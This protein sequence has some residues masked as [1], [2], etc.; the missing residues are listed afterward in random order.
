MAL[1]VLLADESPTIKKVFQLALQDYAVE[2]RSVSTGSDVEPV[3]RQFFPDIIFADV[4]L[5]KKNGYNVSASL[6]ASK[7]LKSIPIVLLCSHFMDVDEDKF[8]VSAANARLE[9]PF[10][11]KTLRNVIKNL[12]PKTKTQTLSEYLDFPTLP[13]ITESGVPAK[14]SSS[15]Q[16][17]P[18]SSLD[19]TPSPQGAPGNMGGAP[20]GGFSST[21]MEPVEMA[22]PIEVVG[23]GGDASD[24]QEVALGGDPLKGPESV[25][26]R[27]AEPESIEPE[28]TP[29]EPALE[30]PALELEPLGASPLSTVEEPS[31]D[32]SILQEQGL[33]SE[34]IEPVELAESIE[35]VGDGG[36]F[37]RFSG[38]GI[39]WGPSQGNRAR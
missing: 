7:E 12:V 29:E 9:K 3:T 20:Q 11:V 30:D 27:L 15:H 24:F 36:G 32:V 28:P 14:Q 21:P 19:M 10:D 13:E 2:V 6:K 8:E 23:D 26:P 18:S 22:E 34:P 16:P 37:I 31:E 35:V 1:R 17:E 5:Q 38:S 25:E 4:L 33:S 39:G